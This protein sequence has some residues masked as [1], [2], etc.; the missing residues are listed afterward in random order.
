[1]RSFKLG[2]RGGFVVTASIR[3]GQVESVEL[4]SLAGG[5]AAYAIHGRA[6]CSALPT[7]KGE[8]IVVKKA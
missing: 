7:R 6:S 1:M 5:S 4:E 3:G 8:R 2:A